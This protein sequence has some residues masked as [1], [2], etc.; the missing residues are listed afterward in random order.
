MKFL[1][2]I[3]MAVLGSTLSAGAF[4]E[5][6][7]RT[8]TNSNILDMTKSGISEQT[9]I[10][11]IQR[12]P[13]RFDTSAEAVIELKKSGVSDAVLNAMLSAPTAPAAQP[14]QDCTESL[15]QVLASLGAKEKVTAVRSVRWRGTSIVSSASGRRSSYN[16]ESV[17]VLPSSTYLSASGSGLAK[18]IVITPEFNYLTEGKMTTGVPASTIVEYQEGLKLDPLYVL[19]HRGQYSCVLEGME[20]IGSLKTG[21]LRVTGEGVEGFWSVD[22]ETGRLLRRVAISNQSVTDFSDW[23]QVDGIYVPFARHTVRAGVTTEVT[24]SEYELNPATDASWFQPPARQL[25]ASLTF[26]VRQSESVPYTVQTNGGI[27]TACNISGSTSTSLSSSTYGNTTY[28]TATST[29]NLQMNCSSSDNTI[30]WTHVLNAMFVEASDGNAYIIACDR[31]WRWSKC[32]PLRAGDTFLAE[33]TDKGFLVQSVNGKGREKE[34][35]YTI[36]QSKSLR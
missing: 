1:V 13:T 26:K 6:A 34:A 33:R 5:D 24:I 2:L 23:R 27:S 9:I 31:A 36:L 14:K 16:V 15:D 3:L 7:Q 29:P 11:M 22:P 25:T 17:T 12:G 30:R 18:K 8:L 28:G 4:Q 21:K 19:Q 20:Q 32:T 35:T 10:L